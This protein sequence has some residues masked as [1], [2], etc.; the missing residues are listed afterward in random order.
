MSNISRH[1]AGAVVAGEKT[2]GQFKASDRTTADGGALAA[3]ARRQGVTP[4][5]VNFDAPPHTGLT[6]ET[7]LDALNRAVNFEE[8]AGH[9]RDL[10]Y[11]DRNSVEAEVECAALVRDAIQWRYPNAD[12]VILTDGGD[13]SNLF[14]AEVRDV[15]GNPIAHNPPFGFLEEG[16]KDYGHAYRM[17]GDVVFDNATWPFVDGVHRAPG[18]AEPVQIDGSEQLKLMV[19]PERPDPNDIDQVRARSRILHEPTVADQEETAREFIHREYPDIPR[20]GR[21]GSDSDRVKLLMGQLRSGYALG[22]AQEK[23]NEA[24]RRNAQASAV[25]RHWKA[26]IPHPLEGVIREHYGRPRHDENTGLQEMLSRETT[27]YALGNAKQLFERVNSGVTPPGEVV[28]PAHVEGDRPKDHIDAA[29]RTVQGWID[30]HHKVLETEGRH[31][32]RTRDFSIQTTDYA[33]RQILGEVE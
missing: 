20:F 31:L 30:T 11:L 2:G 29:L 28:N 6:D 23:Y 33:R 9:I 5:G 27:E 7:D 22:E 26:G 32:V 16:E 25:V 12:H 4:V 10:W 18:F 13:G 15:D 19:R 17:D 8:R 24:L 1:Q 14:I 21:D 3:P